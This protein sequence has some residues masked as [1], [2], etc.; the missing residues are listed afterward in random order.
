MKTDPQSRK[1]FLQDLARLGFLGGLGIWGALAYKRRSEN[2]V[3]PQAKAC[4]SCP[5]RAQCTLPERK[6]AGKP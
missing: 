3:C 5:Q 2:P 4:E 6:E 1:D